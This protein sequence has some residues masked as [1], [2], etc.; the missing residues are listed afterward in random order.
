M[1]CDIPL[2]LVCC[3]VKA[4]QSP[5]PEKPEVPTTSEPFP[6]SLQF[7]A[8]VTDCHRTKEAMVDD[9]LSF[10]F[11]FRTVLSSSD[12]LLE[13]SDQ[14]PAAQLQ[15]PGD[16]TKMVTALARIGCT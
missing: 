16:L 9:I 11:P 3:H 1:H 7:V 6:F 4:L 13:P 12:I 10:L 15:V 8:A 5:Q 14:G 2:G